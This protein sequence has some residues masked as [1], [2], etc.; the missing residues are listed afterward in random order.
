M[1]S[2]AHV[3]LLGM[4]VLEGVL[5]LFFSLLTIIW[6]RC[7]DEFEVHWE[8]KLQMNFCYSPLADLFGC[9]SEVLLSAPLTLRLIKCVVTGKCWRE[10]W[11]PFAGSTPAGS[12]WSGRQRFVRRVR[13]SV[14]GG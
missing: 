3:G 14:R 5:I 11:E 7:L 8:A 13:Q 10:H 4:A 9:D 6:R 12:G 2:T 1:V